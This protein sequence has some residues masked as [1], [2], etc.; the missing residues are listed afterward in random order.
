M[1]HPFPSKPDGM[2]LFLIYLLVLVNTDEKGDSSHQEPRQGI[3]PLYSLH[4]SLEGAPQ[5]SVGS[6]LNIGPLFSVSGTG[7]AS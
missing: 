4:Y 7:M 6:M 2:I 5:S 3:E 1:M